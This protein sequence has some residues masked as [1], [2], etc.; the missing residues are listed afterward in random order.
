MV[1]GIGKGCGSIRRECDKGRGCGRGR[2]CDQSRRKLR[3]LVRVD[4]DFSSK[5]K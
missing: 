1:I 3:N 4:S 5:N 2:K